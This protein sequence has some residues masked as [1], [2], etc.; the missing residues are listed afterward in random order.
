MPPPYFGHQ[1]LTAGP[2]QFGRDLRNSGEV[3][4]VVA[5]GGATL[6]GICNIFETMEILNRDPNLKSKCQMLLYQKLQ[7][8]RQT[9]QIQV[10]YTFRVHFFGQLIYC[11]AIFVKYN[12][13]LE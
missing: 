9:R 5:I 10:F 12:V 2:A 8:S 6:S 4:T 3:G 13:D 11:L 7:Y 1:S